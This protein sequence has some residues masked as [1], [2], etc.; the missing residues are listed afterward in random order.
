MYIQHDA[1]EGDHDFTV[2]IA[3]AS[4]AGITISVPSSTIVVT[5]QDNEGK[6]TAKSFIER[7]IMHT[8]IT[9]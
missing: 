2:R 4:P 7:N 9:K 6:L 1:L 3:S 8:N 5:I